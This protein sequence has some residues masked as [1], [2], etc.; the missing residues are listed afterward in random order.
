MIKVIKIL[1]RV[2]ILKMIK[3]REREAYRI[4]GNFAQIYFEQ[5]RP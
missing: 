2:Q 5:I 4:L 3:K 1:E